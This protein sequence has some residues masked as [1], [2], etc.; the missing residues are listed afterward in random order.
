M[1]LA[2]VYASGARNVRDKRDHDPE[3]ILRTILS[4]LK[5][6][7][8]TG[9][10]HSMSST[11]NSPGGYADVFTGFA[12]LGL[13]EIKVAIKR[14]RVHILD[15]FR[16]AKVVVS[17]RLS[18]ISINR[19]CFIRSVSCQGNASLVKIAPYKRSPFPWI[20]IGKRE[21]PS[22]DFRVDEKWHCAILHQQKPR[23]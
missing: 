12:K 5:H 7:D 11:M 6:L 15:D 16:L 1:S 23:L 20:Y 19:E 17:A 10:I 14:L 9:K 13:Y 8:L 3:L 4:R 22:V 2:V 21:I 18:E